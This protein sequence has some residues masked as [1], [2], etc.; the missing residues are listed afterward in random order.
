[1]LL[2]KFEIPAGRPIPEAERGYF[3]P[4]AELV[5]FKPVPVRPAEVVGRRIDEIS[6]NLGTYGMG[7]AGMFGLRLGEQWLVFALWSAG[8]W[9]LAEGRRVHD[10]RYAEYGSP[11]P[12]YL[13][14]Q[15]D[16]LSPRMLGRAIAALEVRRRSMQLRLDD[17]FALVIDEDPA[18]RRAWEG[19]RKP[20]EFGWRDDLRK[21]VFLSP[22]GE[23]WI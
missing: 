6:A 23:I 17:G 22:T 18:T 11:R 13:G 21:A 19:N 4:S 3:G 9:M 12:W 7:G 1:M 2:K 10:A 16:E 14:S 15:D 5:R 20:R 8:D